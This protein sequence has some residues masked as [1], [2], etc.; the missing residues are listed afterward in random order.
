MQING[1]EVYLYSP[2][3]VKRWTNEE[4]ERETGLLIKRYNPNADTM[5]QLALNVETLAN[6]NYLFGEMIARLEFEYGVL[7]EQVKQKEDKAV[8]TLRNEWHNERVPNIDYFKARASELVET[9]RTR[10]L[11]KLEMLNRFKY[12]YKV[13]EEKINA[14]K[15][16]MDSIKYE[17]F[18]GN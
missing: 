2:F 6:I 13:Y 9:E 12:A 3:D 18:G 1:E 7:K 17:E 14:V 5:Y 16:K 4:V 11:E 15:K 10:C 8:Y